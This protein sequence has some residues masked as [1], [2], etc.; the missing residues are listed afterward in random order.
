VPP[1][2][3]VYAQRKMLALL[4]LGFSSGLPA[5]LVGAALQAWLT[6]A[7]IDVK[8]I[9]YASL[10]ALPYAAKPLWAPLVDRFALPFAGRR[11]GWL[12]TTQLALAA[13][14]WWLSRQDPGAA[15]GAF[16][17]AAIGVAV[18][19]A[20]HDI[21]VDAYRADILAER[22]AGAG[23]AGYVLGFRVAMVLAGWLPLALSAT[24]EWGVVYQVM[25][26]FI[27]IGLLG[28]L[29]AP[30]PPAPADPPRGAYGVLVMPFIAFVRRRGALGTAAV[31]AFAVLYKLGDQLLGNLTTTF[32][33]RE[34]GFDPKVLGGVQG[35]IGLAA[36][37][38]GAVVGG[39]VLARIG[40]DR[41]LWIFGVLQAGSNLGYWLLAQVGRR[42]DWLV[43]TIATEN[44]C[45][46]LATAA[47]LGFLLRQCD[48]RFSATQFALLSGLM[49]LGRTLLASPAGALV[50][51]VGWS[52]FFLI[53]I[54]AALP[55]LALLPLF[56]PWRAARGRLPPT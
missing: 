50:E 15:L 51:R 11:R 24:A 44:F 9:G 41:S 22:E 5:V 42:Y 14:L 26:T 19:S 48:A 46:G 10:I 47:F 43:G 20:T 45:G 1:A 49:T 30:E 35:G 16:V 25:T 3:A 34:L 4:L 7:G 12:F 13:A 56:A 32:L 39:A 36:T 18:A 21:V 53:S 17:A 28:T 54:A 33:L 27:G 2:L 52:H 31:L 40:I 8:T 29:I 37:V 23:V 55:G 38:L 6:G